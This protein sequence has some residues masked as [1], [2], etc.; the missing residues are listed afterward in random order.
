[1]EKMGLY[2]HIPFCKR[3][4]HFCHFVKTDYDSASVDRY[5]DA[6]KKEI[7]LRRNPD[8]IIDTIFMGGG[9]PSLLDEPRMSSIIQTVFDHFTVEP[10]FEWTVEMN[11]EDITREKLSFMRKL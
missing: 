7:R 6:L 1:M 5:I 3:L 11:P 8:Y 9:S 4:C 10:G 2:I